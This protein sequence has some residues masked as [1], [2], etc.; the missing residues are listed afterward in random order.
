DATSQN[1]PVRDHGISILMNHGVATVTQVNLLCALF[2]GYITYERLN[3]ETRLSTEMMMG[4]TRDTR[5]IG[6]AIIRLNVHKNNQF[7]KKLITQ[8][9]NIYEYEPPPIIELAKALKVAL[10]LLYYPY[11]PMPPNN[12]LLMT[13]VFWEIFECSKSL[14]IDLIAFF[15]KHDSVSFD[16]INYTDIPHADKGV[17]Q[18]KTL[19]V[20]FSLTF[21][22]PL[23]RVHIC[24]LHLATRIGYILHAQSC[25]RYPR[26]SG[27]SLEPEDCSAMLRHQ[28]GAD[29]YST[30]TPL[31]IAES[32]HFGT[33]SQKPCGSIGEYVVALK[34]LSIHCNFGEFLNRA[35]RDRFVC[36]LNNV[37]IQNKLLTTENITFDK[38]CQIA[39]SMEMAERNTQEFHPTTSAS[40]SS[41]G[42]V[43]QIE[44]HI[45]SVCRSKTSKEVKPGSTSKHGQADRGNIQNLSLYDSHNDNVNSD[46]LGIYSLYSVESENYCQSH[47]R[48]NVELS[49]N[50]VVCDMEIDTAADFSIM[51][52]KLKT[53][54]GEILQMKLDWGRVFSI[55]TSEQ[56]N[57]RD[58]LN[59]LLSK[60]KNMF[61]DSYEGMKGFEA[62]ITMK[63]GARPV[64]VKP[65]KVPYALKEAV[66]A[67]LE[68]LERNGVIKK[69][70]RTKWASPV[71]VVPKADK[72]IRLC[73][74]Y[75][76][77]Y[78]MLTGYTK[79]PYGV[80]SAP[81]IFHDQSKMDQILQG[82]KK[83][84]CKQDDILI[85]GND[86]R[87]NLKILKQPK[88]EFLRPEVVYLG[89]KIYEKGLHPVEEKVDAVRKA[90]V[91]SNVSELRSF[92]G[93]VQYYHSFLP[94]LATTLAPLHKL[95]KKDV[96]W[97]WTSECQKAHD[98]CKQ[99]L[100]SDTL[101]VH[102]DLNRKLRLACDASS[103]GLGAVLS[104]VMDDGH[105]RP[106]AHA[107]RT[108]SQ[109]EKNYAQIEREALSIVFGVK[110]F[111][112]FLYGRNFTLITDHKPLL[113][114][115]GPRSAIPT[116]AAARMQR[117]ALV[118]ST[119]DYVIEYKSSEKH[120]NCDA[121]SRLPHQNSTIGSES[122]IYQDEN[123]KPYH[124]RKL[125]LSCEQHC[126]LWG[127][128]VV[129]PPVF[130]EKMLNELHWEHPGVCG[131]KAIAR[132]CVWWPKMDEDIERAVKACT[133]CQSVRN[134]PPHAPLIPWKWPTRPFQRVHIDFCQEG[135]DYFLVVIDSHSKWIEVK[136]MTSTTTQRTLDEL[137]LIF[138]VYGLPE[139][140]VSDNGPQFTATE[141]VEF[142]TKNGIKHTL[143][144]PYHPQSN[145]AAERS[146]RVVKEAL[147]KQVIQGTQGVSMKHRLA[148]F[149][150]RYR[151]TPHSTTGVSPGE[152][153]MKRRLRTRLS[154]VKPDLA[155]VVE[156]KAT[157]KTNKWILDHMIK[158]HDGRENGSND[159]K[160]D[161]DES[162]PP[163]FVYYMFFVGSCRTNTLLKHIGSNPTVAGHIFQ[164]RPNT[165]LSWKSIGLVFQ[166]ST[167]WSTYCSNIL[168]TLLKDIAQLEE[169]WASIPKVVG[170]NPTVAGHIFQGRPVWICTQKHIGQHIAQLEEHW[171]SIPKVN[172]LL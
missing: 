47:K 67:E 144:P 126:V 97:K 128:R 40:A 157:N 141:F 46:E 78:T 142:M 123:L 143:V 172:I 102:Y 57:A 38:A 125:E 9:T 119:Y 127:S 53:Y 163:S 36:G 74:D 98:V 91:P 11:N 106:I 122:A 19:V 152:L 117:W 120:A 18:L 48:Y 138:A 45:A 51:T 79:L 31:E 92:L 134:T 41:E 23:A 101:L 85:G 167:Y 71:V 107:S 168:N 150:L 33:R 24:I 116:L 165:L 169:H 83:C 129:I 84:V 118:L 166:R 135:K 55:K 20:I 81:K 93:M 42:T 13:N 140:V 21:P 155:Q 6:G 89:L 130:R 72:S 15:S 8:N 5:T 22:F 64:F 39:K 27:K 62:H 69:T 153:M 131:M 37:K 113:A 170:S 32:F 109:T 60:Y 80:K 66:E 87:E 28:I 68:K 132:T 146:V 161:D 171:A 50:G 77:L 100:T 94:N 3:W 124:N 136:H 30:L 103:Y 43:N 49:L 65:R 1:K 56:S 115:L 70:E 147:A 148:N 96:Q 111:H 151:T 160:D 7:Q 59:V 110:K 108:L 156:G 162:E 73:G 99:S 12:G 114:I 14:I 139:E 26:S 25:V 58:Q 145:G 164:A 159:L 90:P 133:V 44:S 137:R 61:E 63:D 75:K 35:L 149:L 112:Q 34:K 76:V 16:K 4:K 10:N 121:L 52:V 154:L 158:A 54:T 95:F 2:C 29:V 82:I 88:C 104:H 105:E 17:Y 86:W